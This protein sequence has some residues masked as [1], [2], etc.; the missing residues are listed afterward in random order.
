MIETITFNKKQFPFRILKFKEF[1]EVLISTEDLDSV[2]MN[3]SNYISDEA[4][5]ID[6]KIFYYV[7]NEIIE[8]SDKFIKTFILENI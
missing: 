7:P 3:D 5:I 8:R 6:E 2:I 4:R 1:G